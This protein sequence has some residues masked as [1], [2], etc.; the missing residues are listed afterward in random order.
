MINRFFADK[1]RYKEIDL[2]LRQPLL[3]GYPAIDKIISRFNNSVTTLIS[4]ENS[5]EELFNASQWKVYKTIARLKS[6]VS[7]LVFFEYSVVKHH[8]DLLEEDTRHIQ[9]YINASVYVCTT[10]LKKIDISKR[11]RFRFNDILTQIQNLST[12]LKINDE[13]SQL[14]LKIKQKQ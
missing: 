9:A 4:L 10:M 13:T 14:E 5:Q 6:F 2:S 1:S 7:C 8:C 11:Q 12:F 3:I